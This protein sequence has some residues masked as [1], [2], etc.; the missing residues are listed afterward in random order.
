MEGKRK[1]IPKEIMANVENFILPSSIQTGFYQ[2]KREE[3][4]L[5]NAIVVSSMLEVVSMSPNLF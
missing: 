1:I 2:I 4:A 5:V 3:R